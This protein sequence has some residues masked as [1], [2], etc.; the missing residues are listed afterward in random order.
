M[1]MSPA[2]RDQYNTLLGNPP[3]L[4]KKLVELH[5]KFYTLQERQGGGTLHPR[6]S[7]MVVILSGV[8]I[9]TPVEKQK[10]EAE[11]VRVLAEEE[12]VKEVAKAKREA[13]KQEEARVLEEE[14]R[15]KATA[16]AKREAKKREKVEA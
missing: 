8:N 7:L 14:E 13:K 2:D 15:R 16:K 11:E 10:R 1:S 5:E 6:L 3:T 4:P 9:E 12:R